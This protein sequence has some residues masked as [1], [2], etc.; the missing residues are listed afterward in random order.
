MTSVETILKEN[1]V[2]DWKAYL[3]WTV[4]TRFRCFSTEIENANWDFYSQT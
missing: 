1:K 2:E 3:R 4:L